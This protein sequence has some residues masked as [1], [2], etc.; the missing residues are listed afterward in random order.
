PLACAGALAPINLQLE[1]N[2]PAPGA[3]KRDMLLARFR[4]L[5]REYPDLVKVGRFVLY[6]TYAADDN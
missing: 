3:Q 2:L 4:H 6:T 1:Q 5:G